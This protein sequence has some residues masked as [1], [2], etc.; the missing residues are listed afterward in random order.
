[1]TY[2]PCGV[3]DLAR[4]GRRVSRIGTLSPGHPVE[5]AALG[6]KSPVGADM[7]STMTAAVIDHVTLVA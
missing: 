3:A 1:M 4:V 7:A 5:A 2:A 6:M